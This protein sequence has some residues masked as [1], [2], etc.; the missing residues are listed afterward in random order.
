M[1]VQKIK[2]VVKILDEAEKQTSLFGL[3]NNITCIAGC[4]KCCIT[5]NIEASPLEFL[6]AAYE[7]YKQGR[8]N[9]FYDR[10]VALEEGSRCIF[11]I[12]PVDEGENC[13]FY[14]YRGLICR[15]FGYSTRVS[16][17]NNLEM[18]TCTI[19]KQSATYPELNQ[20]KLKTA[21]VVS[22]FYMQLRN[23]DIREAENLMPVNEAIK[24]AMEMVLFHFRYNPKKPA[25][26]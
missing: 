10:I 15:V 23:I 16:K 14:P 18:I 21:P 4:G 17:N 24:K 8:I 2:A 20:Q 11:F 1:L 13:T 9:E 22:D 19:I 3:R 6:P 5:P 12:P 7:L 25:G 26:L